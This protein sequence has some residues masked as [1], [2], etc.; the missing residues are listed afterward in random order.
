MLEYNSYNNCQKGPQDS[1]RDLCFIKRIRMNA[2][3]L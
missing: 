1:T 3:A 2:Y